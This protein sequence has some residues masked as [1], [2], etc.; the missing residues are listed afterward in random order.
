MP[1]NVRCDC[2]SPTCMPW[3]RELRK[4]SGAPGWDCPHCTARS[5]CS[6]VRLSQNPMKLTKGKEK[7]TRLGSPPRYCTFTFSGR[8]QSPLV[9]GC[10]SGQ[11]LLSGVSLHQLVVSNVKHWLVSLLATSADVP[12]Q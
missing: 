10:S 12:S 4:R 11:P 6:S 8:L 3:P 9:Y 2:E 5:H 1:R 7:R